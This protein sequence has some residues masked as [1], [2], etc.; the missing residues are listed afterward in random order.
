MA[1]LIFKASDVRRVVEHTIRTKQSE[2]PKWETATEANGWTPVRVT[3]DEPVVLF[4]H[5]DG[6]YLMSNGTPR[7]IIG[8]DGADMLDRKKGDGRSFVAYAEGCHPKKDSGWWDTSRGLVGG[9]DFVEYLPW[10]EDMLA[11]LD[12]GEKEIVI[13]VGPDRLELVSP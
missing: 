6:V 9:D 2:I 11:R 5:D 4:V 1:R 7:D 12:G 13:E 3:P 10:T 8:P